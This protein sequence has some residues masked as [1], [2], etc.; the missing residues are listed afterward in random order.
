MNRSYSD[1][2]T[3]FWDDGKNGRVLKK[4]GIDLKTAAKVFDDP[5]PWTTKGLYENSD[6]SFE[7]QYRTVGMVQGRFITVASKEV[8]GIDKI[9]TA[10]ISSKTEIRGYR[11]NYGKP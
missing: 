1:D 9:I 3:I 10:W 5:W 11:E 8:E 2:E 6:G 7:E 4:H